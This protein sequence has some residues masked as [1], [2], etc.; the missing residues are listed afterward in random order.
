MLS[1]CRVIITSSLYEYNRPARPPGRGTSNIVGRHHVRQTSVGTVRHSH[2]RPPARR[3][4]RSP[5]VTGTMGGR[6][7]RSTIKPQGRKEPPP[8]VC[9][10]LSEPSGAFVQ[11]RACVAGQ[12][13]EDP[14]RL[15][16][17]GCRR[18]HPLGRH[19]WAAPPNIPDVSLL[20]ARSN[21]G[22]ARRAS[23]PTTDDGAA[24]SARMRAC[25]AARRA[26]RALR[27]RAPRKCAAVIEW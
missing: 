8:G 16:W 10:S 20:Y 2:G 11:R 17:L 18:A 24:E 13:R 5:I 7:M 9:S 23:S 3:P 26:P 25:R 14:T 22:A 12:S 1:T 6:L 27:A 19:G 4:P 15:A 21:P